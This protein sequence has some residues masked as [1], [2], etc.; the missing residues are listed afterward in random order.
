ML[1]QQQ[2]QHANMLFYQYNQLRSMQ[3]T[4]S[5]PTLTSAG[6][7]PQAI[8]QQQDYRLDQL[9][10]QSSSQGTTP[11]QQPIQRS[12]P[13]SIVS[14]SSPSAWMNGSALQNPEVFLPTI[15]TI[16]NTKLDILP[17]TNTSSS[18]GSTTST[19]IMTISFESPKS[20]RRRHHSKQHSSS[21]YHNR[22]RQRLHSGSSCYE[23]D[24]PGLSS[25]D[26]EQ[27]EVNRNEFLRSAFY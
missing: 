2:H 25:A 26:E 6:F 12:S 19:P 15:R 17:Y 24:S 7:M 20:S 5:N 14:I 16:S 18:L 9:V 27:G 4:Y 11:V 22:R 13:I 1:A 21:E 3:A 23:S 8:E 10:P